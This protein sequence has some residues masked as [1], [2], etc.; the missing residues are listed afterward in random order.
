MLCV[1]CSKAAEPAAQTTIT[2]QQF[3]D[4]FVQLRNAQMKI[5]SAPEFETRKQEILRKAGVT[6]QE[7]RDFVRVRSHEVTLM[8][9]VWD[10]VQSRISRGDT[11]PR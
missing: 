8:A 6:E 3:V 11:I 5:A 1:A 7:L 2:P 9:G 10:S 4:V